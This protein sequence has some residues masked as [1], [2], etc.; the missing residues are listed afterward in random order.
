MSVYKLTE[1][2]SLFL[3]GLRALA[4]QAVVI[5][6]A[7]SFFGVAKFLHEPNFPWMQNIAVV[8]FFV[9]SGFVI[10]YSTAVKNINGEYSLKSYFVDRFSRI[11]SAYIPA[12]LFICIIDFAS[13]RL[14]PDTYMH[15]STYNL[16]TLIANVFMLQDFPYGLFDLTSLASAG[17]LWTIAIEW[18]VYLCFGVIYFVFVNKQSVTP[19]LTCI[20]AWCAILPI[21]SLFDGRGNGLVMVW[22]YGMAMFL[23]YPHYK[24]RISTVWLEVFFFICALALCIHR[25]TVVVSGYDKYFMFYLALT[26]FTGI[27][28]SNQIQIDKFRNIIKFMASYSF[29]LYLVHLSILDF[30]YTCLPNLDRYIKFALGFIIA[31]VI[32]ILISRVTE[33]KLTPIVKKKMISLL[34]SDTRKSAKA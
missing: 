34:N 21:N 26:I 10:T 14:A 32:A 9:M 33:I 12:L 25:Q 19:L 8:V 23:A 3:D 4:S 1:R 22:I 17:V 24:Q 30:I 16:K 20:F 7:L 13:S 11:Y 5:G 29:S 15:F 18:W 28:L 6:H 27:S 2:E 31:N